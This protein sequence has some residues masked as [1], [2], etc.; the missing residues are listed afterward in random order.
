MSLPLDKLLLP[1]QRRWLADRADVKIA[2]KGRRVGLTWAE[3]LA[4]VLDAA[5]SRDDGG[6]NVWYTGY[7]KDMAKEFIDDCADWARKLSADAQV[8]ACLIKDEERDIAAYEMRLASGNKI[9][10]LSSTPRNLRGKEGIAILDEAAWHRDLR[11]L[12]KAALAFLTWGGKVRILSTH[13]GV[14]SPFN[15]LVVETRNGQNRYSLHRIEFREAVREG[16]FKKICEVRRREWSARREAAWVAE[17]YEYYGDDAAEELDCTPNPF[18]GVFLPAALV[19]SRMRDGLSVVRWALDDAFSQKPDAER[20]R[21]GEEFLERELLPAL[22]LLDLELQTAIGED[23]ARDGDLTAIVVAQR[24]EDRIAR[25]PLLIE[26]RN[27]PY[28]QQGQ[29]M[30]FLA[31]HAPHFIGAAMDARGSGRFLSEFLEGRFGARIHSVTMAREWYAD[32]MPAMK[33]D[34]EDG[35]I[36]VPRDRDLLADLRSLRVVD[37]IAKPPEKRS[38]SMTDRG[39]RHGDAAIALALALWAL[40]ARAVEY[41]FIRVPRAREAAAAA[42]SLPGAMAMRPPDEDLVSANGTRAQLENCF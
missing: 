26:M 31:E 7:N 11:S 23:F 29:V 22:A 20:R 25:C 14:E 27:V 24:G 34:F 10:A 9:T 5:S 38:L 28:A 15:Q 17:M 32:A 41:G 35:T 16:L 40:K 8:A 4:A 2:E 18:A 39:R 1:Y 3:S 36:E 33:K 12:L 42:R 6:M 37:G 30:M 13:N 19:E 21:A